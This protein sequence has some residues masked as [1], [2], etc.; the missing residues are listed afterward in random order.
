MDIRNLLRYLQ[1]TPNISAIARATGLNWRTIQRYRSWAEQHG[2]LDNPLP[3]LEDLQLL[4]SSSLPSSAPPQTVSSLEPFRDLVVQL[5]ADGVE[6]SAILQRLHER[7]YTGTLSS[8]YRFLKRLEPHRSKATVRIERA[9][10]QEAQVDFGYAGRL[11]D[12][13]TLLPRKAWAF[14]MTL[15]W[16]RHQYVE[17]VFDQ[18]LPTW[19]HL[20]RNAFRFFGGVPKRV[21]LDNLKAGITQA[22]FDDPHIQT[23]YRECAEHYGFLLAPCA[24]RTPDV[25]NGGIS[26]E[27]TEI[28]SPLFS[29]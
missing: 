5:H 18:S 12:P 28:E 13:D 22:C 10:A 11:L 24:P 25:R 2:L 9:P 6:G 23:S 14:V 20:H 26:P 8:L 27:I 15:A 1:D 7:G 16:S 29:S 3:S 19:I 21:V 4:L 17:F